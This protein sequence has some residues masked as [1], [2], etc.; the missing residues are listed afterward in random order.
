ML[1]TRHRAEPYGALA[2]ECR[3][4]ATSTPS[5]QIKNHYL[6]M[7]QDYMWLADLKEQAHAYRTPATVEENAAWAATMTG[8]F[9]GPWRIVE[10]PDGF[11]VDDAAGQQ[12]AVFYGLAEPNVAR[13][14]DFLTIDEARQ[15]AVDFAKLAELREQTL[16]RSE[17]ATSALETWRLPRVAQLP[18]VAGLPLAEMPMTVPKSTSF[19]PDEWMSTPLFPRPSDRLSDRTKFL[20]AIAIAVAALLAGYFIARNSDR[21]VDWGYGRWV[22]WGYGR[23]GYGWSLGYGYYP[24]N[25]GYGYYPGYY[26]YGYYP[27]GG[28]WQ[29]VDT[30]AGPVS[31]Y[32]CH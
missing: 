9:P 29:S 21:S 11:A 4:L 10:Y 3:R 28:C 31:T 6:L 12:L 32:V 18:T 20:I 7:A 25:Y 14:T 15:M 23:W 16:G 8:R 2:E 22:G 5:S 1:D 26:G 24:G 27:G 13:Q 30:L 19:E 17:V